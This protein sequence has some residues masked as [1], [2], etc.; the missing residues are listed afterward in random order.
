MIEK[1]IA[2]QQF[3]YQTARGDVY[4]VSENISR[5]GFWSSEEDSDIIAFVDTDAS[6][7]IN[8][9]LHSSEL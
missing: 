1:M 4:H 9:I 6:S 7:Y 5:I 8:D 3:L 2:G